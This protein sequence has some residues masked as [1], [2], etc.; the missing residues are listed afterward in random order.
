MVIN[1]TLK[2]LKSAYSEPFLMIGV[3]YADRQVGYQ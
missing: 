3:R 1:S 2:G